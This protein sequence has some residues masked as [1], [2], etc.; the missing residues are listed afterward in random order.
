MS[1]LELSD[2]L[3]ESTG[4]IT[5]LDIIDSNVAVRLLMVLLVLLMELLVLLV[6]LLMVLLLV[7][8]TVELVG[9]SEL[10]VINIG[11]VVVFWYVVV[12]LVHPGPEFISQ[13]EVWKP[14]IHRWKRLLHPH[15]PW[16]YAPQVIVEQSCLLDVVVALEP[17]FLAPFCDETTFSAQIRTIILSILSVGLL[18]D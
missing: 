12:V 14:A 5:W 7:V 18:H 13:C 2:E 3:L 4:E 11:Y 6:V 16:Q 10:G 17:F 8:V 9:D 1:F 15:L